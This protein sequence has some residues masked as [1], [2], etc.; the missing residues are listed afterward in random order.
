MAYKIK[1]DVE[2]GKNLKV[3]NTAIDSS[4]VVSSQTL[5]LPNKSGTLAT[6]ND[7]TGGGTGVTISGNTSV[8]VGQQETYTI[9]NY[10]SF[11]VYSVSPNA[12]IAG[13]SITYTAPVDVGL[14]DLVVTVDGA[15]YQFSVEVKANGVATPTNTSP[16]NA[17]TDQMGSATLTASAFEWLGQAD[18]HASSDWQVATDVGFITVIASSVNDTINKTS[19]TV[20]G[21]QTSTTYYWRVR[22]TG[23]SNGT[24]QYSTPT[25][26]T[27]K[28]QFGG[29]IGTQGGQ[30]F[31]VGVYPDTLPAGFS[32]MASN[33]DPAH[34]NYGNYTTTNGSIMVFV[35]KFY[36]RI[37]NAASPRFATYGENAID[38]VGIETYATEALANAAGY[39]LHRAFKD[40]GSV[41]HGF[42][43][44]KYLASKDGTTTCKSVASAVPIS[45][46]TTAGY[47][48]SDGMTGCTG[49]LADA[50]VLSRAR[51]AGVFNVASV[52]MYSALALLSLAHGQAS[53]STTNCAWYNATYNY[54]KGCNTTLKDTND[55]TV[56]Y[57]TA[58]DSGNASKPLTRAN[59]NFA[60]TTHNGQ[61]SGVADLNGSMYQVALGITDFSTSATDSTQHANGNVYVLK[62]SVALASLTAGWDGATD[63]WGNTASLA[64]KY[65]AVTGLFPWGSTTGNFYFG[66]GTNEV[67]SGAT[68]GISYQR[69]ACGVQN[70]TSGASATGTDLFGK[71]YCSQYNRANLFVRCSGDWGFGPGAGVFFRLWSGS[72]S[73][74]HAGVGFR[75]AA[76]GS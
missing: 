4:S 40:G 50:V 10:N 23:A 39:A 22:Y 72:R 54:P 70:T 11:S 71:D 35:P 41:K 45:L 37:G 5:Y 57:T 73:N 15:D 33:T 19:W 53:V 29:L 51:G 75:A 16:A 20:T 69:T 56:T 66:N 28:A 2:I 24:S 68:S 55:A 26:F 14:D 21:L 44:D 32:N 63:A 43:I 61:E 36:Y 6:T 7:I 74:V 62:E 42:F 52:F 49:I 1:G 3:G 38:V 9:T 67:F 58:G 30:G 65:D 34:A 59:A 27:T 46:A 76:F 25:S 18:T 31:G 12:S 17:A 60:K 8:F 13:S 47:T 64:T 48:V